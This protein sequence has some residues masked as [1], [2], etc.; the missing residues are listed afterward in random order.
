MTDSTKGKPRSEGSALKRTI[1]ARPHRL[2][3]AVRERATLSRIHAPTCVLI[4]L[5][6]IQGVALAEQS[7]PSADAANTAR[8][9]DNR[10]ATAQGSAEQPAPHSTPGPEPTATEPFAPMAQPPVPR[11]LEEVRAQRQALQQQRRAAHQAR[12]EALDPI[13]TAQ[14]EQR[15]EQ[16][17]RRRQ[18]L[19]GRIEQERQNHLNQYY[20][21]QGP[22]FAPL[23]PMQ[24]GDSLDENSIDG[25]NRS[26]QGDAPKPE[27]Q[28]AGL[29]PSEWNNL[30]Y[31]NGW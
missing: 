15:K 14:R 18:E 19:R 22:W 20:L 7:S 3:R 26:G 6:A 24:V 16:L 11:W 17:L 9:G 29:R 12:R 13:G 2:E 4:A 23:A 31:Y 27:D 28:P 5:V 10:N 25:E 21:N 1:P 30:W 8:A